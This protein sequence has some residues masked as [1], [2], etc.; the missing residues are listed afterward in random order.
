VRHAAAPAALGDCEPGNG[1][2]GSC[3]KAF[4][5]V[6]F[7][8]IFTG[9]DSFEFVALDRRGAFGKPARFYIRTVER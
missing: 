3:A 9:T 6:P 1:N 7:R 5:Y 2:D 8:S 4:C